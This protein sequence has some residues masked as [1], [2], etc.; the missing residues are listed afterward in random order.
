MPLLACDD[1]VL[2]IVAAQPGFLAQRSTND[3]RSAGVELHD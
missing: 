3:E 1:S 2:V